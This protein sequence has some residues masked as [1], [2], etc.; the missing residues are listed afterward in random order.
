MD[1]V[2]LFLDANQFADPEWENVVKNEA[3]PELSGI[4]KRV[5]FKIPDFPRVWNNFVLISF[6]D[7][8]T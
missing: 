2:F 7:S 1:D 6:R 4:L 3:Q 8:T 5:S